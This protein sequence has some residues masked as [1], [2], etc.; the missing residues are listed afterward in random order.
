MT[1][2]EKACFD[3][4][5]IYT[6]NSACNECPNSEKTVSGVAKCDFRVF[7]KCCRLNKSGWNFDLSDEELKI[8]LDT[9]EMT[10][11]E[12]LISAR[13]KLLFIKKVKEVTQNG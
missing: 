11:A 6:Y 9:L 2:I 1:P 3:N 8:K 7:E 12:E 4:D 5:Y 13:K 10:F